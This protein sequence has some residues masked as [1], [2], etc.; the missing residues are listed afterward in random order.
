[1]TDVLQSHSPCSVPVGFHLSPL[2]P[3]LVYLPLLLWSPVQHAVAQQGSLFWARD[4]EDWQLSVNRGV[5]CA[6]LAWFFAGHHQLW[7][8]IFTP[9]LPALVRVIFIIIVIPGSLSTSR[10]AHASATCAGA[11][12]FTCTACGLLPACF[13][14]ICQLRT[15]VIRGVFVPVD[16]RHG[17]LLPMLLL[18]IGNKFPHLV[19]TP[20]SSCK[21]FL[22][23]SRQAMVN[24]KGDKGF[25]SGDVGWTHWQGEMNLLLHVLQCLCSLRRLWVI[26]IWTLIRRVLQHHLPVRS[27][28]WCG[29]LLQVGLSSPHC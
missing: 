13:G 17:N 7:W 10:S 16:F 24:E 28:P 5:N 18:E 27:S 15:F 8:C 9:C 1:M 29:V 25:S 22:Q 6:L 4:V 14:P 2:H 26:F 23:S 19:G 12:A 21:S 11:A 20:T 3:R